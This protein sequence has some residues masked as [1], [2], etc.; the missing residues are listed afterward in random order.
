MGILVAVDMMTIALS[1]M[2]FL[3]AIIMVLPPKL[4]VD[5]TDEYVSADPLLEEAVDPMS[6]AVQA[7]D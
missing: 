6:P 3:P 5:G 7:E 1:A 2:T 4:A